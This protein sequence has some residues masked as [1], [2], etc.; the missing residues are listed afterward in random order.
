M[1]NGPG[2]KRARPVSVGAEEGDAL[3]RLQNVALAEPGPGG[4]GTMWRAGGLPHC[5]SRAGVLRVTEAASVPGFE[6]G[7]RSLPWHRPDVALMS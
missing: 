6:V 1:R 7:E 5:L 3:T 4:S 2:N